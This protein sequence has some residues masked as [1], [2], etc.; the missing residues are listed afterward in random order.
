MRILFL[1]S[2]LVVSLAACSKPKEMTIEEQTM[3]NA[4]AGYIS[5]GTYDR[6]CN[7][8]KLANTNIKENPE[9]AMYM[10]NRQLF[11]AR[12]GM[13]WKLRHPKGTVE[14]GVASLIAA[15]KNIDE[16]VEQVLKE[17]GCDSEAGKQ[18]KQMYELY[19][20]AHPAIVSS[21]LDKMITDQGG[22]VTPPE[23]LKD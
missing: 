5:A 4:F 23:A 3:T 22:E 7:G 18:A 17:K 11:G 12:M 9:F 16:K 8:Q 6:V 19:T 21:L 15:E 2:I 10:G 1:L 14:E 13:L 20:K